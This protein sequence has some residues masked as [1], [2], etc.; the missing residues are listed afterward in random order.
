MKT[1]YTFP[2]THD[3]VVQALVCINQFGELG[4]CG[5]AASLWADHQADRASDAGWISGSEA[6]LELGMCEVVVSLGALRL[7]VVAFTE[8]P[9]RAISLLYQDGFNLYDLRGGDVS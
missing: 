9:A 3:E 1:K 7:M 8:T 5:A 4:V 2:Y 6:H